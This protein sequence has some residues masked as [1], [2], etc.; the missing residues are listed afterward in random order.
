MR[1]E[2]IEQEQVKMSVAEG[3]PVMLVEH[4]AFELAVKL[5]GELL[6]ELLVELLMELLAGQMVERVIAAVELMMEL[7]AGQIVERVIAADVSMYQQ[8]LSKI[9]IASY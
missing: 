4:M 5:T 1:E 2:R 3:V 8:A 9:P 7:L 6:A